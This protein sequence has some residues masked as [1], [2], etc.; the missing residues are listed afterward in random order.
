MTQEFDDLV[1]RSK[2]IRLLR[3]MEEYT[4]EVYSVAFSPDGSWLASSAQDNAARQWEVL[5]GHLVSTLQGHYSS[6]YSV[7]FSQ[8]ASILESHTDDYSFFR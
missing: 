6:V 1:A 3:T 2:H 7:A 4:N 5:T 8:I